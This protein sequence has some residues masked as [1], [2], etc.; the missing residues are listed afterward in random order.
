MNK[1]LLSLCIALIAISCSNPESSKSTLIMNEP[2]IKTEALTYSSENSMDSLVMDGYI[3]WDRR[4][5]GKRP[6]VLV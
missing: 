3:A 6:V 4:I 2:I 1:Y 5:T